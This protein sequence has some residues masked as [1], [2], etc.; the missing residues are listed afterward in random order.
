MLAAALASALT[1]QGWA[2]T[3]VLS[4]HALAPAVAQSGQVGHLV[5]VADSRGELPDP[6]PVL[7]GRRRPYV[8]AVGT[9]RAFWAMAGALDRGVALAVL[10]ADQPFSD[11]AAALDGLLRTGTGGHRRLAGAAEL[12]RREAEARRFTALTSR[13]QDVLGELIAGHSAAEIAAGQHVSLATVR[14]HIRAVLAKLGVSSQL[15]AVA[16][17]HRSCRE[18]ELLERI[19][20]V[21]Q[22]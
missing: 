5:L 19:R 16:L 7:A 15:A 22:F 10:D 21:H 12:H 9:V 14:S 8:V 18:P 20:E 6:R 13:E 3:R 4:R 2:Y 1:I 11:L 17:A